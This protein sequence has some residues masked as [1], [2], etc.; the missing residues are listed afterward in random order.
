MGPLLHVFR[1]NSWA[2]IA[3]ID[4]CRGLRPD[5]LQAS[6]SGTYGTVQATI[7]H[8]LLAEEAYLSRLMGKPPQLERPSGLDELGVR[9]ARLTT[10]WERMI[11]G[12]LD[13]DKEVETRLGTQKAGI[14]LAQVINHGNEHRGQV[15]TILGANGV[16]PPNIDAFA[17]AAS[18]G[19]ARPSTPI[20]ARR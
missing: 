20:V 16:T 1:H 3:L 11:S 17:Y 9:A 5:Q 6:A 13:P 10:E 12:E 19:S 7:A 4:F 2:T 8:L 14:V 15:C 18:G